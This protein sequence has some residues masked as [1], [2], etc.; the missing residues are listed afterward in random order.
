MATCWHSGGRWNDGRNWLKMAKEKNITPMQQKA[1]IAL[2]ENS[3]VEKAAESI[4]IGS[5]TLHRWLRHEYFCKAYKKAGD[6]VFEQGIGKIQRL[7]S[8][9]AARLG[10]VLANDNSSTK[11]KLRA[12]EIVLK[13]ARPSADIELNAKFKT[14]EKVS[15]VLLVNSP[16]GTESWLQLH[17]EVEKGRSNQGQE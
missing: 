3:S 7:T 5:R 14:D 6:K 17:E 10:Q 8:L 4:G 13:N 1:I 12:S 16:M 9:A 15:G 11:D 2:M